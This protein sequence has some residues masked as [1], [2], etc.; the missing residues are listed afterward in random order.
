[1][2]DYMDDFAFNE[3]SHSIDEF[4]ADLSDMQA[5][6]DDLSSDDLSSLIDDIELTGV[7]SPLQ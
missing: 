4:G 3:E 2:M 7:I 6:S 1:M 5:M